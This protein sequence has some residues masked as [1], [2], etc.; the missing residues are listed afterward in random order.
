MSL[1][2]KS[3][4]NQ[5]K[6]I[7]QQQLNIGLSNVKFSSAAI[8]ILTVNNNNTNNL[9]VNNNITTSSLAIN[10]TLPDK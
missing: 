6:K 4:D 2:S 5:D 10:T 3:E 7:I 1:N 8:D 9:N